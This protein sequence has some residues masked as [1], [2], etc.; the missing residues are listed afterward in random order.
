[1]SYTETNA[2][3]PQITISEYLFHRLKQ[4][5]IETIFGLSGEYN[6]PLIDKLYQVHNLRWAGNAN[7]LNAAYA[8]DGYAR[9]KGL[10][11]LITTFGVGELSA[12]NGVAGSFAEHVGLLHIVGMP[13]TSAQTKQLLLHHTLGNGD[14]SVFHR[15]ASDIAVYNTVID[16][17]D[18][19]FQEV[20][21]CITLAWMEQRPVYMGM[22]V[23]QVNLLVDSKFLDIPLDLDMFENATEVNSEITNK[24]LQKIYKCKHPAIVVDACTIRHECIDEVE[25]FCRR[26]KFPV[27]VTPMG[28]GAIN[29]NTPHFGGVFMGS[30]SSPSVREV[31]DF[32][33]F[34]I[35][36]GSM[37]SEFSTSTFHFVF[38]VKDSVLLFSDLVKIKNSVYANIH[39]KPLM[40]SLLHSLDESKIKYI[41]EEAPSMILPKTKIPDDVLLRQEW[42]WNEIS[43]W[44]RE[45]DIII[46]EIGTSAFGINQTRFPNEAQGISQ[47]LWGSSGYS[48]G[49]CLGTSFAIQEFEREHNHNFHR[50]TQNVEKHRVILF[51]GDGA[52]QLTMQELSTIIRWNL[53]PYIFVL[54]NEGYSVDRFLHP[55]ANASYYDI[56]PWNYL[57]LM[58]TFNAKNYETKKIVT[59]GDFRDMVQDP[60]FAINDKIRMVE[61][62]LPSTDVP[63]A[64]V[65]TWKLE[66]EKHKRPSEY[67][68]SPYLDSDDHSQ[69]SAF[70]SPAEIETDR[71]RARINTP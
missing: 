35:V 41:F 12:L 26:T 9:L 48:L 5:H 67:S 70:V 55:E 43:H 63:Q 71:K 19:C 44:F 68:V 47:S 25:E 56:Q 17:T 65:D 32:A 18:L 14:Y 61:I 39:I 3:P 34:I 46:T 60:L 15:I 28:K 13:P 37:L 22:P 24:I 40:K 38:K 36:I 2:L 1:M 6:M 30:L 57:D 52:F 66:K 42:V 29:E 50:H 31:V 21:K 51:V 62:L 11:V 49:A 33:D 4:L 7:E 20:D 16:D 8:A 10:G 69:S 23:N 58:A 45:G 53:T 54:N 27:F 59:V 64:L